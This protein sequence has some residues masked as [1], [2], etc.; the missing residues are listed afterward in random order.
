MSAVAVVALRALM[1]AEQSPWGVAGL[2]AHEPF[3][4][5]PLRSATAFSQRENGHHLPE[6]H[7]GEKPSHFKGKRGVFG[8]DGSP[9]VSWGDRFMPWGSTFT[10]WGR[11]K[12][13]WGAPPAPWGVGNLARGVGDMTRGHVFA[14]RDDS[15]AAWGDTNPARGSADGKWGAPRAIKVEPHDVKCMGSDTSGAAADVKRTHSSLPVVFAEA[16]R[17][18]CD[19]RPEASGVSADT[20]EATAHT[21]DASEC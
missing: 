19:R 6:C 1:T 4:R 10:A 15:D 5:L 3:R 7:F 12:M 18:L 17:Q 21:K 16:S 9:H 14:T 8:S 11:G 13:A 20:D 2:L